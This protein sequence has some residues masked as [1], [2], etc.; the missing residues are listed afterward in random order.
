MI[1]HL[2]KNISTF[3]RFTPS[4]QHPYRGSIELQIFIFTLTANKKKNKRKNEGKTVFAAMPY[5]INSNEYFARFFFLFGSLA[6][7]VVVVYLFK[8]MSIAISIFPPIER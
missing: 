4:S 1:G 8:F 3:F 5:M 2:Y 7:G 6:A